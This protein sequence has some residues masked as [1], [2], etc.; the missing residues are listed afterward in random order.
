MNRF[1]KVEG[2]SIPIL[3]RLLAGTKQSG[4]LARAK[5]PLSNIRIIPMP[6][7]SIRIRIGIWTLPE[8]F[9]RDLFPATRSQGINSKIQL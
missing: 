3:Q 4:I 2:K 1:L 7:N 8:I 9:I 6:L 5:L